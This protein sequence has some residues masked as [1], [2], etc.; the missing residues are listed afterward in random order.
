MADVED[1]PAKEVA[2][3]KQEDDDEESSEEELG[4]IFFRHFITTVAR[5]IFELSETAAMLPRHEM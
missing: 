2:N 3:A 5:L 4:N 1:K